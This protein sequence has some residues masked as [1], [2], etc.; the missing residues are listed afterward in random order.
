MDIR[1]KVLAAFVS[2]VLIAVFS[3]QSPVFAKSTTATAGKNERQRYIIVLDDPP[4][5]SYDG[6][7]LA[8]PGL[9]S[10]SVTFAPTANRLT[11]KGKLD[12]NATDELTLMNLF[13]G[14]GMELAD[15]EVLAAA[16]MDWRD[17][18]ELERVNGA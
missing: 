18:D 5:A 6:R 11:A 8:T 10:E 4:L 2:L 7:S 12:I 17:E 9:R 13:T 15:A 14:H 1:L 16:V 3:V